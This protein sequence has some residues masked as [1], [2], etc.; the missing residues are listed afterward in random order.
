M[1][2]ILLEAGVVSFLAGVVGYLVGIGVTQAA[3]PFFSD[4]HGLIV[5][6]SPVIAAGAVGLAVVLGL[7][8]GI[9]P[10][11]MAARLDPNEALRTL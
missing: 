3:L 6:F 7:L 9:Y 4:G 5:G 11:L 2:I 10:A 1:R 8:A